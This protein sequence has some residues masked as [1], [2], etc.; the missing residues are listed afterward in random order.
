LDRSLVQRLQQG[1]IEA[2]GELYEKYKGLVYRTAMAVMHDEKAAEDI[3]QECFVSLYKYAATVDVERP[4]EP[5]LY[6]VTVNLAYDWSSKT[7]RWTQ[8][9]EDLLEWFSGL[10]S[11][12]PAPERRAEEAETVQLVRDVVDSLPATHR[13]VVVLFYL[14]NQS[15]E[16]I[17]QIM[18]LPVGTIKSRLYYA[19]ERL[20][21][22]LARRQRPV[23]EMKYE[24][25]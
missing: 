17:A 3:L 24:F 23:P 4:L 11:N 2:L 14:E 9:V 8:P 19:R 7:R 18:E 16:E 21:E 22:V 25:T 1:D 6:R 12:L 15:V 13:G 10:A 5:W 20:R